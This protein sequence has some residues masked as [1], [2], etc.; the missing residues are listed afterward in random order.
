MPSPNPRAVLDL[1]RL[2]PAGKERPV[3]HYVFG[4]AIGQKVGSI[5]KAWE[6]SVLKAHGVT[7]TS[8]AKKGLACES[9]AALQTIDLDFHH[10]RHEAGS[11]MLEAG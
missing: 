2:D 3:H 10:L 9:R 4:D 5:K 11:R 1:L 7:P 6:K 8:T